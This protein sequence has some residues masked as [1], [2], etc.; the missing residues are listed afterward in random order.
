MFSYSTFKH[1]Y[2]IPHMS[3]DIPLSADYRV[4]A[5]GEEI[6]VYTCRISRYPFN[7]YWPGYQRPI[8][9]SEVASFVNL[10]GDETVKIGRAHV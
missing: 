10:V 5:K 1:E 9:Q 2:V 7:T 3:I 6:P 8:E 4:F